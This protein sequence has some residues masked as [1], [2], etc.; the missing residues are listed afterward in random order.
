MRQWHAMMNGP[1][2]FADHARLTMPAAVIH[3]RDD[4]LIKV[5]AGIELG[6]RMAQ[7]ELHIYPGMG[8][9]MVA[10]LWD[11]FANII[12]RTVLRAAVP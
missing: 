6:A 9:E 8:H 10:P 3:G 5:A 2:E 12:E 11:E 1:D 4:G 7:A